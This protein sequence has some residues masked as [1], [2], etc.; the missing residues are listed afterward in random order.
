[1]K[2]FF[3]TLIVVISIVLISFVSFAGQIKQVKA[4]NFHSNGAYIMGWYWLRSSNN[5]AEW[6][7]RLPNN[8]DFKKPIAFCF[9]TLSTNTYSGGAGF[10]SKLTLRYPPYRIA[11]TLNLKNDFRC[12]KS[13]ARYYYGDSHGIG[14][15]SHGCFVGRLKPTMLE[16]NRTLRVKVEYNGGHHTAVNKNSL[17]VV[18]ITK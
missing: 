2:K 4:I 17:T 5:Y 15:H 16:Y 18:F 12:L 8:V 1:M 10:N 9:S 6:V 13:F 11:R 7:V 3:L 14:Y